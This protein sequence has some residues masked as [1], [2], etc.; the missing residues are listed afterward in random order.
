VGLRD[1]TLPRQLRRTVDGE[2]VRRI[3]LDVRALLGAVEDEVGG[4][5][6]EGEAGVAGGIR[7]EA[8]AVL[9]HAVGVL[10]V[11]LGAFDVGV[12]GGVHEK[13]AP[14]LEA[15]RELRNA[16]RDRVDVG[17]VEVDLRRRGESHSGPGQHALQGGAEHPARSRDENRPLHGQVRSSYQRLRQ[18]ANSPVPCLILLHHQVLSRYQRMVSRNPASKSTFGVHP[19]FASFPQSSA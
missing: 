12:C 13:P 3:G 14:A 1:S 2:R 18:S 9:V 17:D 5:V 11:V 6:D 19:I 4:H 15:R 7:K 10:R 16:G 8:R